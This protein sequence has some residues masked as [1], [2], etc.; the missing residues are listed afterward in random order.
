MSNYLSI[1]TICR[2]YDV[3]P[4]TVRGWIKR[5]KDLRVK[6][7]FGGIKISEHSLNNHIKEKNTV[8]QNIKRPE[9]NIK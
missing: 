1:K 2:R 8:H 5:Y 6:K 7:V 9:E 3:S 4:H